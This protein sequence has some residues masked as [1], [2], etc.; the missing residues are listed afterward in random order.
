MK[1]ICSG[2]QLLRVGFLLFVAVSLI[3]CGHGSISSDRLPILTVM[4]SSVS[5]GDPH[6]CSDSSN[7]LSLIFNVYEALVKLDGKGDFQTSLAESWKVDEDGRTWTFTLRSG[8]TFHN[9]EILMAEDVVA[10]LARVLDPSIGGSFGTQG[11]YLSY[12]DGAEI[13]AI[14]DL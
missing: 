7:R 5:I 13:S 4:Q 10:T 14:G 8:V 1:Y 6:I 2:K 3:C 9:G 11:V 12:L